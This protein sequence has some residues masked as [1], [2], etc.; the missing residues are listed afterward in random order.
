MSA[1]LIGAG[2][3][4]LSWHH[5]YSALRSFYRWAIDRGYVDHSPLPGVVPTRP[6]GLIPYIFSCDEL[7]RILTAFDVV[8]RPDV[9]LE[10]VTAR[11]LVLT[12]YGAGLRRQEAIFVGQ[13]A[14][15]PSRIL[16]RTLEPNQL[17]RS[18]D[19]DFDSG[20]QNNAMTSEQLRIVAGRWRYQQR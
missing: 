17:P 2:P 5:K 15:L 16:V 10:P 3:V 11:T 18:H 4:T 7:R 12:L 1:F 9:L 14:M 6:P 8:C 13:A 20:W 19:I